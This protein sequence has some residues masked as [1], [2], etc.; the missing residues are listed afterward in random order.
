M[1]KIDQAPQEQ[2]LVDF[3]ESEDNHQKIRISNGIN[4]KDLRDEGIVFD[5]EIPDR[6][7]WRR[8]RSTSH[9]TLPS[10]SGFWP[11][12]ENRTGKDLTRK[13]E[14]VHQSLKS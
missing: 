11:R 1:E 13:E 14:E 2:D 3:T 7:S 5:P 6:E 8:R 10:C 12:D 9:S 4:L